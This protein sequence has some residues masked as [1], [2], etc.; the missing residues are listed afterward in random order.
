MERGRVGKKSKETPLSVSKVLQYWNAHF[1]L[2]PLPFCGN[3]GSPFVSQLDKDLKQLRN[4]CGGWHYSCAPD[5][6]T[7]L[8]LVMFVVFRGVALSPSLVFISSQLQFRR[9][10]CAGSTEITLI[11]ACG[12]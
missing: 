10:I 2:P 6:P 5:M 9:N 1:F 7:N 8:T 3:S 4:N 11:Y 12:L